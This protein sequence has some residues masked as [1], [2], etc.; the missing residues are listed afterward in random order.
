MSTG[1]D[2]ERN[3]ALNFRIL[4]T[5]NEAYKLAVMEKDRGIV[6]QSDLVRKAGQSQYYEVQRANVQNKNSN[7]SV[8]TPIQNH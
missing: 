6:Y 3:A 5:L 8:Q 7:N 2:A 4:T 1:T